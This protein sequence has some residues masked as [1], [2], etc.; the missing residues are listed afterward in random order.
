MTS[1]A[2][3]D[4]GRVMMEE[5]REG[6]FSE[7]VRGKLLTWQ[8]LNYEVGSGDKTFKVLKDNFGSLQPGKVTALMGPSGAGKSSLLN[9]LAGRIAPSSTARI[10]GEIKLD[11]DII[12]PVE[13]RTKVAYVMQDD[14]LLPTTTP[15]EALTFSAA[16]RMRKEISIEERD[17]R[18]NQLLVSLGIDDCADTLIGGLLF[19]GISGGQRK[20][21]SVGVDLV[22]N[23]STIFLDEPTSGLDAYSAHALVELL[24]KISKTGATIG[25][26]IH[27]PSSEVFDLFDQVVLLRGGRVV[28]QGGVQEM[29]AFFAAGGAPL[30]MNYNPA[31]HVMFVMQQ[32]DESEME[33]AGLFMPAPEKPIGRPAMS[34]SD[35]SSGRLLRKGS[36]IM[37]F[38]TECKWLGMREMKNTYR[39]TSALQVRF[40]VTFFLNL[41]I[42]LIF[43][44]A[45]DQNDVFA[46]NLNNHFGAITLVSIMVM[47]GSALPVATEFPFQ[48]PV[49]L[50]EYS[51][52]TYSA[53]AYFLSR[54]PFELAIALCQVTLALL[55]AYFLVDFR[56]NFAFFLLAFWML[57]VA[58]A[59]V[60]IIL[61][62]ALTDV[63]SVTEYLPPL[64]VPQLL[65]SGFFI[66]IEDIPVWLRWAQW[67]CSLK[68]AL[69]I[70]VLTEFSEECDDAERPQCITLRE[71]NDVERDLLGVYIA[72][73]LALIIIF[74]TIALFVLVDKS[75]TVY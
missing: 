70:I 36:A 69:N 41:L 47:F 49:F 55:L 13:N 45:G 26:T 32:K 44:R 58:A 54:L 43:F 27:Q 73:L 1:A 2:K 48:R 51:S 63:K 19:T 4:V 35:G 21:T 74:R 16:L 40:G 29:N 39:N 9:V 10:T 30:P 3:D 17:A 46:D 52:S 57:N 64:F 12:D 23:P 72:C 68:H 66:R 7:P 75:K 60:A 6:I 71:N 22:T 53:T 42:G 56:G 8:H 59:S 20:R 18:V 15:R 67:L 11:G 31:D 28:Y 61:G 33:K 65:F 14:A 24:K 38:L 5:G 62:C 25:C 34:I 37:H 50:R